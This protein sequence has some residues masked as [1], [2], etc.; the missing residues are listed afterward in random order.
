MTL[1]ATAVPLT[2]DKDGWQFM[3]ELP[4]SKLQLELVNEDAVGELQAVGVLPA[5]HQAKELEGLLDWWTEGGL[6]HDR[7]EE[8]SIL[9][10]FKT[11]TLASAFCTKL[12]TF[13]AQ[14]EEQRN[15][16]R[17]D[18]R[19]YKAFLQAKLKLFLDARDE[20]L[21]NPFAGNR[22]QERI[23][24]EVGNIEEEL[25]EEIQRMRWCV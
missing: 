20:I 16:K 4:W 24:R 5:W 21:L 13:L 22:M 19:V 12:N 11:E 3:V 18:A 10:M 6:N 14:S 17:A 9:F 8:T 15:A 2:N 1:N 25:E 7:D 23:R